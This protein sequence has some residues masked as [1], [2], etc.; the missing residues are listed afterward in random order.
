ME[1]QINYR[2]KKIQKEAEEVLPALDQNQQLQYLNTKLMEL[3]DL[4]LIKKDSDI[5]DTIIAYWDTQKKLEDEGIILQ[6]KIIE[7]KDKIVRSLQK[8]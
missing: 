4:M 5:C 1:T 7:N 8:L 2:I 6:N 3:Y